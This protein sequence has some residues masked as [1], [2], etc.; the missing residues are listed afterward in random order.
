MWENL[1][2]K[3]KTILQANTLLVSGEVYDWEAEEFKGDP[4]VTITSSA[5]TSD[6]ATTTE[7][8]RVFALTIRL[9]VDR[10]K[11]GGQEAERVTREIVSS[12]L[13]DFDKNYTL[14][15]LTVPTGYAML[16]LEAANSN[17]G[18]FERECVYR[19]AEITLRAH[20]DVDVNLIS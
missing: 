7:N 3:I 12:I 10:T 16:Y 19:V 2:S 1:V 9:F 18:Y 5:N 15:G 8:E 11:R 14:A 20:F 6:Y 13:D 17:W 4:A